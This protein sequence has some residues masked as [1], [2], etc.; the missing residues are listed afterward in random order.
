MSVRLEAHADALRRYGDQLGVASSA[1]AR[2]WGGAAQLSYAA[3]AHQVRSGVTAASGELSRISATARQF[4][5]VLADSHRVPARYP[6]DPGR[7]ASIDPGH[8]HP[9]AALRSAARRLQTV[10][11]NADPLAGAPTAVLLGRERWA[12]VADLAP[13]LP[14]LARV[15]PT[16]RYW[17]GLLGSGVL[18]IADPAIAGSALGTPSALAAAQRT[19]AARIAEA[20]ESLRGG[21]RPWGLGAVPP[22]VATVARRA[23]LALTVTDGAHDVLH[24]DPQH[25]GW[26][27]VTTRAMGGLGAVGGV[28][29]LATTN[30]IG[31]GVAAGAV[32]AYGVWK[33]GVAIWDHREAIADGARAAGR[34]AQRV[35]SEVMARGSMLVSQSREAVGEAAQRLRDGAEQARQRLADGAE[36]V[37]TRLSDLTKKGLHVLGSLDHGQP[38]AP[39]GGP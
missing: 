8:Q 11:L 30:P 9:D 13:A 21:A 39:M 27:D 1:A 23:S 22:Q 32:T 16:V 7:P 14:S 29:L 35:G 12:T 17:S 10:L 34:F 2:Q 4:A 15:V 37:T 20:V 31:L 19:G 5:A 18:P 25:P 36:Q 28:G 26:R 3:R 33:V 6:A 24:G 38:D